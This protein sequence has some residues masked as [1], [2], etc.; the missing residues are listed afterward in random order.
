[1][2]TFPNIMETFPNE[3][4]KDCQRKWK[5]WEMIEMIERDVVLLC[6][7]NTGAVRI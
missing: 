1:M 2:Q 3:I 7:M 4:E 5:Y 6:M